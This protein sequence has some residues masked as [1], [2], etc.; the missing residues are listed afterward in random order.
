LT[1]NVLEYIVTLKFLLKLK[2]V[3]A[4]PTLDQQ[5]RYDLAKLYQEH[6]RVVR[7]IAIRMHGNLPAHVDL[8]DLVSTGVLGLIDASNKFQS[9]KK[10]SFSAFAKHRIRGSILDYLRSIDW[11]SRG[12]R[13][14]YK[15]IHRK[16]E[17][18]S[19]NLRRKPTEE[20]L[21]T[22][23]GWSLE[24]LR[25][26]RLK[27]PGGE[28]APLSIHELYNAEAYLDF[29]NLRHDLEF[30]PIDPFARRTLNSALKT[31]KPRYQSVVSMY[32][33]TDM[34]MKEIGQVVDVNESRV[35]QMHKVA[36][37]QMHAHMTQ[38]GFLSADHCCLGLNQRF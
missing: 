18:L 11:M 20:E 35:C 4:V 17:E 8:D 7:S 3:K 9:T 38:A 36:L 22:A 30:D 24:Q 25:K 5:V 32:Y 28:E 34:T 2:E 6:H 12:S 15:T 13:K 10:V 29:R 21:A 14:L 1:N 23:L 37:E 27:I 33:W 19:K 16:N 31:L 26:N